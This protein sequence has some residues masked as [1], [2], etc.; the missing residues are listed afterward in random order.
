MSVFIARRGRGDGSSKEYARVFADNSWAEIV[1]A[2]QS[3]R[4]PI[5]W[6]IGDSKPITIDGTEYQI[7]II[8]KYHDEYADGTGTAPLTFQL[9][10]MYGT[11]YAIN[12]TQSNAGGWE[13]CEMRTTHLPT[14]LAAM[15]AEVQAGIR[16]VNKLTSAGSQ[17]STINTT[18]DK[19]FL[20]SEVEVFGSS[21]YSARGEG[22]QYSYYKN[23]GS[24][25]RQRVGSNYI[26]WERSPHLGSTPNFCNVVQDGNGSY[27]SVITALGVAFAFCF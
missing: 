6:E 8:G 10:D 26:W 12:S 7:D 21:P 4:V 2:C 14:I 17:S 24:K 5:T 22:V 1:E 16:E 9:H 19:L 23:G 25:I 3:E 15:P 13:S 20:L 18:A 11:M 27:T